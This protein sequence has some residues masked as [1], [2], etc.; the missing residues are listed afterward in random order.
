M[1]TGVLAIISCNSPTH[2]SL[3]Q[4]F[5]PS[6][7][8]SIKTPGGR[9]TPA[10]PSL[11]TLIQTSTIG[12]ITIVQHTGCSHS[13]DTLEHNVRTDIQ[14]LKSDPHIPSSVPVIG[15]VLDSSTGAMRE[16]AVPRSGTD[17]QAE[18]QVLSEM[19]DFGPFW[20]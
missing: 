4:S 1:S 6:P 9:I 18:R 10:L 5:S 17:E 11:H 13:P 16:V 3:P 2:A 19:E 7:S 8:T 14:I 20:N 12:M 15:Y